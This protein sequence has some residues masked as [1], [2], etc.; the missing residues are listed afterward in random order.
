MSDVGADEI[1]QQ[2]AAEMR[3][4]ARAR[5][6]ELHLVLVRLGVGDEL[7]EILGWKILTHRKH[8]GN[9]RQ[10]RDRSKI[11]LRIVERALVERLALCVSAHRS[12]SDRVAI[13][14]SV[15]HALTARLS[16]R[17]ADV[18]D[19]D[20]LAEQFAH[21]RSHDAA[22]Y[23][24]WAA[25]SKRNYQ[26]DGPGRVILGA[27]LPSQGEQGGAGHPDDA[28]E[29]VASP[30]NNPVFRLAGLLAP[31]TPRVKVRIAA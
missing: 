21:A 13:G 23:I 14:A 7:L 8:D 9:L 2:H 10:Q 18:F 11:G 26:S 28:V 20:L 19:H 27:G 15:G 30:L 1:V 24:R 31:A 22:E 12:Y 29:H 17:A 16:S 25:G 6:A 5:G 4:G 3:R